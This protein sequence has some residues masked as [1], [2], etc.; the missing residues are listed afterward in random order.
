MGRK[1]KVLIE[2]KLNKVT[3]NFQNSSEKWP[4][5]SH[6]SQPL[7]QMVSQVLFSPDRLL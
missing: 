2:E 6:D 5:V 7:K 1:P 4:K 3:V